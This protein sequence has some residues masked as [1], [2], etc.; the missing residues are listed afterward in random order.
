MRKVYF[1]RTPFIDMLFNIL[2]GIFFMFAIS[3]MLISP[4]L[5][6]A[7]MKKPKAEYIITMIWEDES[8]DDVDL[9]VR[10]P[11][12]NVI[13]YRN[14][15]AGL[16]HLDRD[17]L[18]KAKDYILLENGEYVQFKYNQETV[19]IRGFIK[20]EWIVNIHMYNKKIPGP[21][22]VEVRIDKINPKV[23]TVF[24]KSAT[25]KTDHEEYTMTRFT[26]TSDGEIISWDNLAKGLIESTIPTTST[27][28]IQDG[29]SIL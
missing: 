7:E 27:Q 9:W 2:L 13:Y 20:G 29:R 25:L 26:M 6:E 19:A 11:A 8:A 5:K 10:D 1:N 23:K 14:K 28:T 21:I 15:E 18:G 17:D 16:M 22:N 4:I 24:N 12:G 3:F